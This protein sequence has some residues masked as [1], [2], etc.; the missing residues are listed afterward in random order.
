M[1]HPSIKQH[2]PP[3]PLDALQSIKTVLSFADDAAVIAH[4]LACLE[5]RAIYH[6]DPLC[7]PKAVKDC[8][9]LRFAG[10][11]YEAFVCVFLDTQNR[12]LAFD[13]MFRGTLSQ[14]SVYPREVVKAALR[15]NAGAVI[16]AHNHP[17]GLCEPSA[18][19]RMLTD[20]LTRALALIDVKVLDHFIVAG[21]NYLSFAERGLL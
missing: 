15:I 4:A 3:S 6:D 14:T 10:R 18:T 11:Q 17:S 5:Q 16:F 1:A 7:N 9:R 21:A 19:D 2:T 13:E 8:L 12:V 20:T